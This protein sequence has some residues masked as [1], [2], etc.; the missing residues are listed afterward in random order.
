[1]IGLGVDES[2]RAATNAS[3]AEILE[4]IARGVSLTTVLDAIVHSIESE[5]ADMLCSILLLDP[6]GRHLRHAAAPSL[7]AVYCRAIDRL[8]IGPVAGCCGTAAHARATV[9]VTD[10]AR[11]HRW[12]NHAH[13]AL[14]HGLRACWSTPILSPHGEVLGTVALYYREPRRPTP[15]EAGLIERATHLAAIAIERSRTD[16][17]ALR[18]LA[19][20]STQLTASLDYEATIQQIAQLAVPT[21]AD[22]CTVDIIEANAPRCLAVAHIDPAKRELLRELRRRYPLTQAGTTPAAHALREG[23]TV[24]HADFEEEDLDAITHDA[25]HRQLIRALELVSMVAIPLIAHGVTL[26]VLTIGTTRLGRHLDETHVHLA[27]QL[28]TRAAL[29]LDNARLYREA[30][31]A[32]AARDRALATAEAERQRLHELFMQTPAMICVLQGPEHVFAFA[33]PN[34]L[35]MIGNRDVLGKPLAEVLPEFVEQGIVEQLDHV[36]ATGEA[37]HGNEVRLWW[38]RHQTGTRTERFLN[39]VCQPFSSTG[40]AIDGVFVHIIDVTEQVRARKRIEVLA[41]ENERLYQ[42]AQHLARIRE[43]ERDWLQQVIDALPE[44]IVIADAQGTITMSNVAAG[45][46]T[47]PIPAGVNIYQTAAVCGMRRLDGTLWPDEDNPLARSIFGGE[48]VHAEQVLLQS[49][50]DGTDRP[51]LLNTAPIRDGAGAVVGG[52][53]LFQDITAIKELDRQKDEFLAAVSHDLKSPLATIKGHAQL[54]RRYLRREGPLDPERF[55]TSL[56]SI[57]VTTSRMT[58]L[59]DELLDITGL[60]MG[61]SMELER[62]ATDLGALAARLVQEFQ[63]TATGPLIEFHS[64]STPLV[65]FW[66][67]ERLERVVGNLLTNAVKYTPPTGQV[68]VTVARETDAEAQEWATLTVEDQGLGIPAA[69]LAYI[70]DRF[71]RASNVSGQIGGTGLGLASVRQIV[72]QHGGTVTVRS[73][74]RVGT[75]FTVRLPLRS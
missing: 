4:M 10:I 1:M 12:S 73:Q 51:I 70:F 31:Q 57:D 66:D 28:A 21:L 48:T 24:H 23:R 40:T 2:R 16:E 38:E 61:V 33:N 59:I 11:D 62:Q 53:A 60:E 46:I 45:N 18:F 6:D 5:A 41:A 54:L 44:G 14:P 34:Y 20:A 19:T 71:Y 63:A 36:Y 8:E 35:A 64:A 37:F 69:D 67:A 58:S 7:P 74:E 26:G 56:E 3:Q 9:V 27:Q 49:P 32:V 47:G 30:Q 42:E 55:R 50:K 25:T 39:Y 43:A 29:A 15:E 72:E 52:V 68:T 17:Q 13:L 75:T 65:G 22:W